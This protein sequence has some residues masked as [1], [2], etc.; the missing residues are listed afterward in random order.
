MGFLIRVSLLDLLLRPQLQIKKVCSDI[1][2]AD[3]HQ[4]ETSNK[5]KPGCCD[6][7]SSSCSWQLLGEDEHSTYQKMRNLH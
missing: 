6:H 1:I 5:N 4:K 2:S 3:K 7:T